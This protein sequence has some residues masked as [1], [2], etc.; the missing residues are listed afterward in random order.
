M[1]TDVSEQ[2]ISSFTFEKQPCM[3]PDCSR[4][5]RLGAMG[6]RRYIPENGYIENY[7]CENLKSYHNNSR[8]TWT[9]IST[10]AMSV[11]RS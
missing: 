3:K 4:L 2:N 11:T 1:W 9:C 5:L 8:F 7:R 10:Y 6:T